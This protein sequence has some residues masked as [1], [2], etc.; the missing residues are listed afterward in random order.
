MFAYP[1]FNRKG[2]KTLVKSDGKGSEFLMDITVHRLIKGGRRTFFSNVAETAL[3]LTEGTVEFSAEGKKYEAERKNVF[4][5]L[6]SFCTFPR[7]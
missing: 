7:V 5:A 6:P 2:V 1:K 3:L 4:E